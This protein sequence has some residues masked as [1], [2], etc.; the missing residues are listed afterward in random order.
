MNALLTGMRSLLGLQPAAPPSDA[1]IVMRVALAQGDA[2]NPP[3]L[4]LRPQCPGTD[5]AWLVETLL[6][7]QSGILVKVPAAYEVAFD[8]MQAA[9]EALDAESSSFTSASDRVAAANE[10]VVRLAKAGAT[11]EEIAVAAKAADAAFTELKT[12]GSP[13]MCLHPD[14]AANRYEAAA[15]TVEALHPVAAFLNALDHGSQLA[16]LRLHA[17]VQANGGAVSPE[18]SAELHSH[19]S[20]PRRPR[21]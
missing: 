20:A 9:A 3:H 7:T 8:Q 11:K 21:P 4:P 5:A 1:A 6:K 16:F 19:V 15:K 13:E 14:S 2:L 18:L 17:G 12:A 10:D